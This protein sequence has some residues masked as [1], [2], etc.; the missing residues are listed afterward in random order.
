[1]LVFLNPSG[2]ERRDVDLAEGAEVLLEFAGVVSKRLG[3]IKVVFLS[4]VEMNLGKHQLSYNCC[5]TTL[6]IQA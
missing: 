4:V 5:Y 1:M 3:R 6:A 2:W